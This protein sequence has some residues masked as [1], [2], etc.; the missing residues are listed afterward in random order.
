MRGVKRPLT[1]RSIRPV[2]RPLVLLVILGLLFV[3]ADR[4][5][6]RFAEDEAAAK[7]QQ[8][9]G[10]TAKPKVSIEGFPFLTQ[11]LTGKLDEVRMTADGLKATAGGQSLRIARFEAD[12]RG[13]RLTN[14]FSGA[15]ADSATGTVRLTYADLTKV[16]PPGVTIGYAGRDAHGAGRVKVTAGVSL[17]IVG[18][19]KTS[20][21]SS[22]DIVGGDSVRL[23]AQSLPSIPGAEFLPGL[24]DLLR[25]RID[26]T[27]ELTGLPEGIRLTSVAATA[28]GVTIAAAG[29][30]VVLA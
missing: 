1:G 2:I 23:R 16:A 19:L 30:K 15:V 5:A 22:V 13:V 27:R 24:E 4:L 11:V 14:G 8:S 7:A 28:G 26:F 21:V 10:L 9:A 3:A 20:V 29:S 18:T 25:Q 12:L 17:P 6:M